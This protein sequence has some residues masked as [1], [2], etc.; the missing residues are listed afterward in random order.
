ML[1]NERRSAILTSIEGNVDK[2]YLLGQK[3]GKKDKEEITGDI[4]LVFK[5]IP[6]PKNEKKDEAPRGANEILAMTEEI[7][8]AI[9]QRLDD[10][11]EQLRLSHEFVAE[12]DNIFLKDY[13]TFC[14]PQKIADL[15]VHGLFPSSLSFLPLTV[16]L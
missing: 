1:H 13:F 10:A 5:Y 9:Q 15:I 16:S 12:I 14:K 8:K 2:W 11:A 4:H 3:R 6:L 7:Q